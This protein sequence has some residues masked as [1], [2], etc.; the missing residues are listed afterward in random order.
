MAARHQPVF[1]SISSIGRAASR[2][3]DPVLR[4]RYLRESASLWQRGFSGKRP[5]LIAL[6]MP[7][8]GVMIFTGARSLSASARPRPGA[9]EPKRAKPMPQGADAPVP[10]IWQVEKTSDYETYSNGLRIDNRYAVATRA[11]S[12]LVFP[13]DR[14][15]DSKGERWTEPA[16]IVF[17]TTESLQVPF[18]PSENKALQRIGESLLAFV[19]RKR[20]YHFLID[21]FGRV[22]RVVEETDAADHA[23]YSVWADEHWLY[24]NLN[25]S[26]L[27]VSFESQTELGQERAE[28]NPAQM[29]A[30]AMLTEM[31]RSRYHIPAGNC[32]THAQVSVNPANMLAG[33]HMDWASAFPFEQAGLPDNYARPLPAL[34][35]FGFKCDSNFERVGGSRL[36]EGVKL[37]EAAL[38]NRAAATGMSAAAYRRMLQQKYRE[39]LNQCRRGAGAEDSS[40]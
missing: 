37:A 17:H 34:L 40:G 20:A 35:A 24:V 10:Q 15:D 30:A 38:D 8:L 39:R 18:E 9:V 13:A 7:L 3:E 22:F 25:Q 16:G 21:R 26:F 11:R 14:P 1:A 4:L 12:Y 27:G 33:Y 31:L 36:Y 6:C 5:A 2:I 28:S 32:V 29:R 23:G 19:R